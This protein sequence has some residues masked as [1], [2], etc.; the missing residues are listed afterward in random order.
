MRQTG[1]SGFV[2]G[3]T[4]RA[5]K[6]LH[7]RRF[8]NTCTHQLCGRTSAENTMFKLQE[9]SKF[10][11]CSFLLQQRVFVTVWHLLSVTSVRHQVVPFG[12]PIVVEVVW[13]LVGW[14][15]VLVAAIGMLQH[16]RARTVPLVRSFKTKIRLR[17][18]PFR[19]VLLGVVLTMLVLEVA[20]VKGMQHTMQTGAAVTELV[21]QTGTVGILSNF[22]AG[23]VPAA[24][25]AY[26]LWNK[27]FKRPAATSS[28]GSFALSPQVN[29]IHF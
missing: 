19:F 13:T 1:E 27:S 21:Q 15:G 10:D 11:L 9:K 14:I 8:Q 2:F 18:P 20:T 24:R 23:V 16:I 3:N 25:V 28:N 26:T 17:P 22:T 5:P 29:L 4:T 6:T 7:L 12:L